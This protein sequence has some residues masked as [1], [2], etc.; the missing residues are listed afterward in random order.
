MSDKRVHRIEIGKEKWFSLNSL[1]LGYPSLSQ[2]IASFLVTKL[3]SILSKHT[4]WQP[5]K[6]RTTLVLLSTP[7]LGIFLF[8]RIIAAILTQ[9]FSLIISSVHAQIFHACSDQALIHHMLQFNIDNQDQK[10]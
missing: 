10:S 6:I 8:S 4:R 3:R 7:S 5:R 1:P 9:F 2:Q